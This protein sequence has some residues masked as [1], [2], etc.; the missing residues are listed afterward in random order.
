MKYGPSSRYRQAQ[1]H[2]VSS[3]A[4]TVS[5]FFHV[6]SG[7]PES[8]VFSDSSTK[9]RDV[10]YGKFLLPPPLFPTTSLR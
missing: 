7:K 4:S 8:I 9:T 3:S 2:H 1:A 5:C 6:A 10:G